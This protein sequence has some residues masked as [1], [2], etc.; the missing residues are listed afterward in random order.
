MNTEKE[1]KEKALSMGAKAG[2]AFA[3]I[4]DLRAVLG[5][6]GQ[7]YGTPNLTTDA[8]YCPCGRSQSDLQL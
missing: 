5:Q 2:I 6:W 7:L 3:G 4:Y 1:I 8:T